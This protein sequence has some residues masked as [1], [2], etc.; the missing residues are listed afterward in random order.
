MEKGKSSAQMNNKKRE[1]FHLKRKV[2]LQHGEKIELGHRGRQKKVENF[3]QNH[4]K[5][6]EKQNLFNLQYSP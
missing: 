4:F 6:N 1:V 3:H 2:E 5:W